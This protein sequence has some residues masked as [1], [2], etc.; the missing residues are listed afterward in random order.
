MLSLNEGFATE[1][2]LIYHLQVM[3]TPSSSLPPTSSIAFTSVEALQC[4]EQRAVEHQLGSAVLACRS[5]AAIVSASHHN[6]ME[7]PIIFASLADLASNDNQTT[8]PFSKFGTWGAEFR[9]FMSTYRRPWGQP[10]QE[11]VRKWIKV[12]GTKIFLQ[13]QKTAQKQYEDDERAAG[14]VPQARE[15]TAFAQNS[16]AFEAMKEAAV[17]NFYPPLPEDVPIS[18][19]APDYFTCA[20]W[21]TEDLETFVKK[22]LD[23]TAENPQ[24]I[25]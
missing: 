15:K 19:A 2:D 4:S 8:V 14:R 21:F 17:N 20:I 13:A 5:P 9:E 10:E 23:K 18:E 6:S 3:H 7:T 11:E 22:A 12:E 1:A 25:R 16:Y 24:A